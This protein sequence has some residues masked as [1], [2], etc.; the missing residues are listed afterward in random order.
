MEEWRDIENYEGLYQ[1][2]SLGRVK[3]LERIVKNN[4]NSC[5]LYKGKIL[6]QYK[7]NNGYL[8][9]SLT[10]NSK[11]FLTHRLVAQ[12]FIPNPDSLPCVNHINE[13]KTDN[14]VE[15]LEWVTHKENLEYSG[16][17]EKG[18]KNLQKKNQLF[19]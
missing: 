8:V 1:V 5:Y 14:R 15:N 17:I 12:A 13:V 11:K 16:I 3:S 4:E 9:T 19:N 6:K 7:S 18:I 10:K 2:S